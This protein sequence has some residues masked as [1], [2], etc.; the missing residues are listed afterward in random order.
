MVVSVSNLVFIIV[1][2]NALV[3]D[4]RSLKRRIVRIFVTAMEK[5]HD[6]PTVSSEEKKKQ[7]QKTQT[8]ILKVFG[9]VISKFII[10]IMR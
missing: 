9:F 3:S 10:A 7:K 5:H 4:H 1:R 2:N 8:N 6:E